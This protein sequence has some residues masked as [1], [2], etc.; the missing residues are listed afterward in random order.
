MKDK[1]KKKKNKKKPEV[2]EV[3]QYQK[4]EIYQL[5]E[6]ADVGGHGGGHI[7]HHGLMPHKYGG[8]HMKKHGRSFRGLFGR[9]EAS[10]ILLALV[11]NAM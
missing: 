1:K 2:V 9:F 8:L 4:P 6:E 10:A 11:L 3:V 5:V 7:G